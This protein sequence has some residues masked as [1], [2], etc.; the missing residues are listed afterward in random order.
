M[1]GLTGAGDWR[2]LGPVSGAQAD[3]LEAH[4][5]VLGKPSLLLFRFMRDASVQA[6]PVHGIFTSCA[7]R[8]IRVLLRLLLDVNR[9]L[10]LLSWPCLSCTGLGVFIMQNVRNGEV[11]A[12]CAP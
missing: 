12:G 7:G 2:D 4:L 10:P 8:T 3:G 9:S 1:A 5:P 6:A 11:L